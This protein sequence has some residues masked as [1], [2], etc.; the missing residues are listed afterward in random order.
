MYGADGA[1]KRGKDPDFPNDG[2]E[3]DFRA[4]TD[5][6]RNFDDE[7]DR[8]EHLDTDYE[9]MEAKFNREIDKKTIEIEQLDPQQFEE[10]EIA[11]EFQELK[12]L[13]KDLK[14]AELEKVKLLK[15]EYSSEKNL[16]YESEKHALDINE[17]ENL[18]ELK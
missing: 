8:M 17:F 15:K 12:R 9:E 16:L 6:H 4:I 1:F 11:L 18:Y 5:I 14:K 2:R 10:K 7:I 3:N 13:E